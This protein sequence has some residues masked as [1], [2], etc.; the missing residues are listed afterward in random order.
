MLSCTSW[1]TPPG[2]TT[3][4]AE[5]EGSVIRPPREDARKLPTPTALA[6][7][8]DAVT[9]IV[10][11]SNAKKS[12]AEKD[13]D[14]S[15]AQKVSGAWETRSKVT[16]LRPDGKLELRRDRRRARKSRAVGHHGQQGLA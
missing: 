3:T 10:V 9:V 8:P 13:D 6:A 4:C 7:R 15:R 12:W 2:A 11:P 16:A 1:L 14:G 5:P